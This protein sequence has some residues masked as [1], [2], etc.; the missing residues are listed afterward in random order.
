MPRRQQNQFRLAITGGGTGGHIYPLIAVHEEIARIA[1]Q[2]NTKLRTQ[3]IGAPGAFEH[4]LSERDI[5]VVKLP[6]AKLRGY[7]SLSNFIDIPK[8]LL[9]LPRAF[10][11][12]RRFAP[13]VVFSKGGPGA[14]AVVLTARCLRIPVVIH[15]SDA[16]PGRTTRITSK[17]AKVITLSF[18]SAELYLR[19]G[20]GR[21][22]TVGNPVRYDISHKAL[23][24]EQARKLLGFEN[25]TPLLLVLGGSQGAVQI[26][27]LVLASL[28]SILA[29]TQVLHQTGERNYQS[30]LKQWAVVQNNIPA[31]LQ[32]RYHPVA[33]LESDT[34]GIALSAAD[35]ILSRAGASAIFEIAAASK[36]S[37]LIPLPNAAH[38]HQLRNAEEYAKTGA[39]VVMKA[40]ELYP[41]TFQRRLKKLLEDS[42]TLEKM[43]K[44][45]HQFYQP[46]AAL[47]LAK[48]I[49]ASREQ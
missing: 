14:L 18:Q 4:A 36:P 35:I 22:I 45:A 1:S 13:D 29:T 15:E 26:N 39:A 33:Y 12:L 16:I 49:L 7:F 20:K 27:D 44:S 9:S 47:K 34:I 23:R 38:N 17:F 25:S 43:A 19:K 32:R 3:Y 2:T 31:S 48:I 5:E 30:V 10:F 21:T 42:T 8:F 46:D 40:D 37:I 24:K 28:S 41:H 11:K 6:A